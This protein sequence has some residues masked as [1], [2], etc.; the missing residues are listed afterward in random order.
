MQRVN[1]VLL[2]GT[3]SLG[4]L[5]PGPARAQPGATD[6][7][8]A[9]EYRAHIKR[10]KPKLRGLRGRFS[11]VIQKPFVVIGDA[12]KSQVRRHARGLIRR[13][14]HALRADFFPEN[15]KKILDIYLFFGRK[16]YRENARRLTG[17]RP[18]TPYGFYMSHL[19]A[20][21]MNISTGGGTLAHEIVHPFVEANFPGCPA[22]FNEGLGSLYEHV[23]WPK[24]KIRG[25]L[26][27]RLPGLQQ[28]IAR[29]RLPSF[30][31]LMA[32]GQRDFYESD[33]GSNYGQSR[34][35]LYYLQEKGLLRSYYHRFRK[36][37]PHGDSTGLKTLKAV[38]GIRDM[39]AFERDWKRYVLKLRWRRR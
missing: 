6:P 28:T 29:R 34:Y 13:T 27:W 3:L 33:P 20:L 17:E 8:S 30:A 11:M 38:L 24:G 39:A 18:G 26:N 2:L 12:P 4:L 7:H 22:W 35:L 5:M 9:A 32:L 21:I 25:Y 1:W 14:V 23:G 37:F 10:L 15:P 16:S 36:A 31:T 19:G